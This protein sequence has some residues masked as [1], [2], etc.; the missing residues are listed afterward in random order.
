MCDG[1]RFFVLVPVKHSFA[2]SCLSEWGTLGEGH[3]HPHDLE[4][5]YT[6]QAVAHDARHTQCGATMGVGG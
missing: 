3:S 4:L 1:C 2:A 6:V 5:L